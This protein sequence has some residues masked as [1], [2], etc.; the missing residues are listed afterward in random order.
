MYSTGFL[1][2]L[3]TAV[4]RSIFSPMAIYSALFLDALSFL[5]RIYSFPPVSLRSVASGVSLPGLEVLD[6]SGI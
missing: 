5:Y 4:D 6:C 1:L 2:S 3:F